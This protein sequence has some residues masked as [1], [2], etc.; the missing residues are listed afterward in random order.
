MHTVFNY[1]K[2]MKQFKNKSNIILEKCVFITNVLY[3][4]FQDINIIIEKSPAFKIQETL[5]LPFTN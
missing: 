3:I 1:A 2:Y 4:F 5:I